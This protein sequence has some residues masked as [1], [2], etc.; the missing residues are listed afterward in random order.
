MKDASESSTLVEADRNQRKTLHKA[1]DRQ[2][3]QYIQ[4]KFYKIDI[5]QHRIQKIPSG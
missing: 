5:L 2:N 1:E 4:T 3:A